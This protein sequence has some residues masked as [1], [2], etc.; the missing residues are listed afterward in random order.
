MLYKSNTVFVL[1]E[2]RK[3]RDT[4][5]SVPFHKT[6]LTESGSLIVRYYTVNRKANRSLAGP[7]EFISLPQILSAVTV[8]RIE[9]SALLADYD[10]CLVAKDFVLHKNTSY[11]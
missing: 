1:F 5:Y 9:H 3:R 2:N 6:R 11:N 10:L 4:S 8:Q 7:M